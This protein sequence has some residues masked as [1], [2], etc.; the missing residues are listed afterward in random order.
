VLA[1]IGAVVWDMLSGGAG[2]L[3]RQIS[4]ATVNLQTDTIFAIIVLLSVVGLVVFMVVAVA[5]HFIV[6]WRQPKWRRR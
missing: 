5:E 2:G 6:H 1:V 3:G 4:V